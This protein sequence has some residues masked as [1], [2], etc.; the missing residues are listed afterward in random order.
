[1]SLH[2]NAVFTVPINNDQTEPTRPSPTGLNLQQPLPNIDSLDTSFSYMDANCLD[3]MGAS[4][5]GAMYNPGQD[6]DWVNNLY[7]E[8]KDMR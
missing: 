7:Q 6:M 3:P 1:M 8:A 5:F 4:H 2:T